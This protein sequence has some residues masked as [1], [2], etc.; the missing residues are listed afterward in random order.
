MNILHGLISAVE[1]TGHLALVRVRVGE[2]MMT[3]IVVD[4]PGGASE[5][6]QDAPV[7]VIFKETE[8]IIGV[9]SVEHISLRNKLSGTISTIEQG[10]LLSRVTVETAAGPVVSLITTQAVRQLELTTGKPVSAMIKTNEIML[11]K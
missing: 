2:T 11:A 1:R 7:R 6:Q 10:A 8:V 5:M 4:P 9:G 3:S